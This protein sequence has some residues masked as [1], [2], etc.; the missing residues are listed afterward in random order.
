MK[1]FQ[2]L[3]K[4]LWVMIAIM[5]IGLNS[6]RIGLNTKYCQSNASAIILQSD[7]VTTLA[8]TMTGFGKFWA[9]D[10]AEI[11]SNRS[12]IEN[13]FKNDKD[14]ETIINK[15]NKKPTYK[16]LKSV[17]VFIIGEVV[18][19]PK[20]NTHE[21]IIEIPL[22][23]DYRQELLQWCGTGIIVKI[24]AYNTYI[25]TNKHVAGGYKK[26]SVKIQILDGKEKLDCEVV[27]LHDTQDLALLKI[28]GK[29][30][31]KSVVRG[32]A[33][34]EI[35]EKVFTVGHSLARP[36]MYG[37]G[38]FSGTTI[39]HDVYQLPC[40]GGQSGSGVFNSKGDVIGLVYSVAG[41]RNG[42]LIQWDYTRANVVKGIYVQEF[43]EENLK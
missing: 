30:K 37:E 41:A 3:K 25:L 10:R 1:I 24:D 19:I 22:A 35:T 36:F 12:N 4:F 9:K 13:L 6:Y 38:V 42:F 14:I 29:L 17:T 40:I 26:E 11:N 21:Y 8:D 33:F 7:G 23:V 43:L 20:P 5:L 39:E 16:Y 31:D 32:L 28:R 34:P 27:K 2:D 15:M 18:A